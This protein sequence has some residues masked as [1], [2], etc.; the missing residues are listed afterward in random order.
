M[1]STRPTLRALPVA[2]FCW[3]HAR[4]SSWA[5]RKRLVSSSTEINPDGPI[6]ALAVAALRARLPG[7][8]P[9]TAL[10]AVIER[11]QDQGAARIC[12]EAWADLSEH[13]RARGETEEMRKSALRAVELWDDMATSLP[14]PLRAGFWC[15]ARRQ[16]TR[17][18][19]KRKKTEARPASK[20]MLT[21]LL[22]NL[23]RL[24]SERDLSK[25]LSRHHRWRRRAER[26]RTRLRA[27]RRRAGRPRSEND[28]QRE[29]PARRG[30]RGVQPLDR[31]DGSHRR[32]PGGDRRRDARR[33]RS[34]LY[35]GPSVD[36]Q[37]G[38]LSSHRVPEANLG[39]PVLGAQE[40]QWTVFG[41]GPDVCSG[42]MPIRPPLQLRPH[43]SLNASRL[44]D[45]ISSAPTWRYGKPT[46][47]SSSGFMARP[48][49][50]TEPRKKSL[51]SRFRLREGSAGVSWVPATACDGCTNCS[52]GSPATKFPWSSRERAGRAKSSWLA[53]SIEEARA[54]MALMCRSAAVR[55]P[56]ASSKASFS[57]TWPERSPARPTHATGS[58]RRLT[59]ERFS[60]TRSRTCRRACSSICS[61]S[62]K[63]DACVRLA[64]PR[65]GPSM[66]ASSQRRNVRSES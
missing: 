61:G 34:R 26:R 63:N 29:E 37:V 17:A 44:R 48:R 41:D 10:I 25:L 65:R 54:P 27:A 50:C 66:S 23:R 51:R 62:S 36:A 14:P 1:R 21:P 64:A 60:W 45:T 42:P 12:A 40:C 55:S 16:S 49:R 11:A 53:P 47:I 3:Q 4:A 57:V 5:T 9:A 59:A 52:I 19:C 24:A 8:D 33:P 2:L 6:E 39:R 28:P 35:V 32:R 20:N 31:R 30:D 38:C 7:T 15:D 58:L 22:A 18:K 56:K 13:H 46:H 43:T